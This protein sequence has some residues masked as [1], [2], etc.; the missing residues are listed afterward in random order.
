MHVTNE[1][2]ANE[3]I[4]ASEAAIQNNCQTGVEAYVLAKPTVSYRPFQDERAEAFL[5]SHIGLQANT[6][7]EL[8]GHLQG[9]ISNEIDVQGLH[10]EQRATARRYIANL[11][12][13]FA[14]ETIMNAFDSLELPV[15]AARFPI[16]TPATDLLRTVRTLFSP[17][18]AYS[19]KKFPGVGLEEMREIALNFHSVSG[20][21]G[22][23]EIAPATN[24]GFCVF[25]P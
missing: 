16:T 22:D 4:L 15:S 9:V 3:W 18:K 20:R 14:C 10:A 17:I 12:G 24:G 21:F 11:D 2:S 19:R 8:I 23:V 25:R 7:G 5:T 13:A 1:G 6:E